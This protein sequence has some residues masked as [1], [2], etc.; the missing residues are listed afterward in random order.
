MAEVVS[1]AVML[2]LGAQAESEL[3]VYGH[4]H[5]TIA[6]KSYE[7]DKE[8]TT[9]VESLGSRFGFKAN[10]DLGN[11]LVGHAQLELGVAA[12][13]SNGKNG[14][15]LGFVGLSG[16]FG[17]I[18][19]GSQGQA[20]KGS[21]H[22]DQSIWKDGIAGHPGSRSSNTIKYANSVGPLSLQVDL[23]AND[24]DKV[25][26]DIQG[27]LGNGGA[28]GLKASL[29]DNIELGF[30]ADMN[31]HESNDNDW[32]G[33]SGKVTIGQFFGALA[34]SNNE[35]TDAMGKTTA[36]VDYTQFWAGVNV[37]D[38]TQAIFGYGQKDDGG[39]ANPSATTFG[40]FHNLGG[41]LAIWYEGK[42]DDDDNDNMVNSK[43]EAVHHIG[44]RYIF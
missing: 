18:T 15:R 16:G 44:L 6:V 39:E 17:K 11:G 7:G 42:V 34:W 20:F 21:L 10:S 22:V 23:R 43:P 37:S 24:S 40:V 41:G 32:I 8:S 36:D 30:A 35:Q 38:S 13:K 4:V 12:D 14:T 27:Q 1:A 29:S 5:N 9:D 3:T 19:I 33:V 28:I 31:E 26:D 2:P 25:K